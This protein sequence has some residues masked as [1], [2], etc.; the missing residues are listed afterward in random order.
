MKIPFPCND[1]NT[2]QR[3]NNLA[4]QTALK[5]LKMIT[6]LNCKNSTIIYYRGNFKT[7]MSIVYVHSCSFFGKRQQRR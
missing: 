1:K 6:L 3:Q 4:N 7:I 2:I 5:M